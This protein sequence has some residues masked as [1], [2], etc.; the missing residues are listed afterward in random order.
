MA[1]HNAVFEPRNIVVT[2]GA[3]FIGS[4]FVRFVTRE[5][6]DVHI[7]VLDALTYAGNLK[8]LEGCDPKQV[9]FIHGNICDAEL[10]N[11][12]IPGHD[13]IVH[14]AAESHNDR[15]IE[16]ASPFLKT[17]V[18]GTYT[19]LAAAVQYGLRFHHVSTDEVY[20]D[21]PLNSSARFTESSPY[22][23]S[24]PYAA[25][26][27]SSDHLVRAWNRTYGLYTTISNCSNNYGPYQHVEKFIPRQITNILHGLAPQ[28]YGTGLNVRDWIHV[29]D[30]CR[31]IWQIIT[32][33][34]S[35]ETYLVAA[36]GQKSNVEVLS[37]ICEAMGVS[38]D[39]VEFVA[40][41]PGHDRRYALD[42]TKITTE[43]DWHPLHTDF[44]QGIENTV[45][46]YSDHRDWWEPMKTQTEERYRRQLSVLPCTGGLSTASCIYSKK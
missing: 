45:R 22:N 41:R 12:V 46:W 13:L 11:R 31:A 23:P 21:L 36:Q 8:N 4:N 16:D 2:G 42:A 29:D 14:F 43:L 24:S 27:A 39:A 6:P 35:G 44:S 26:K 20:G 5:H 32:R 37:L 10:L 17:N 40:D 15:A 38:A 9:E 30:H 25:S 7:T 33:G 28:L 3:G 19:L 34:R 1:E 18:E